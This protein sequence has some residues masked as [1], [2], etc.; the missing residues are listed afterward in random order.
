VLGQEGFEDAPLSP[1]HLAS[2]SE[3]EDLDGVDQR[4]G[5]MRAAADLAQDLPALQHS[6]RPFTRPALSR[7]G[8]VDLTLALRQP[9]VLFAALASM[10]CAALALSACG[11]VTADGAP[12]TGAVGEPVPGGSA[13]I[14]TLTEPRSL[15]PAFLGNAY[16]ITPVVGNSLYGQPM[17]DAV[18]SGQVEY[19]MAES[20]TTD[21][22]GASFTL[23][24]RPG[25]EFTDGTPLDA[26]AVKFD[27]DRLRDPAVGATARPEAS[28]IAETTAADALTLTLRMVSPVPNYAE[29]ILATTMNWIASPT[30]LAAGR[31]SFARNP[32][33]AGPFVLSSWQRDATMELDRNPG[34]YD[35]PAPTSTTSRSARSRTPAPGSTPCSATAR[36]WPW[37]PTGAAWRGRPGPASLRDR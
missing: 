11:A 36:T 18:E 29:A 20:F 8:G 3:D 23:R 10:C 31:E 21:D 25:L 1:F 13:V 14:L 34:C 28:M 9:P 6:V 12:A 26:A 19:R 27:W 37:R 30:A 24:L 17:V 33:G 22:G 7:V 5:P 15:D 32:V 2:A 35:A 16:A 4:G